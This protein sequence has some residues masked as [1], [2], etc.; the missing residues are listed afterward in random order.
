MSEEEEKP[1]RITVFPIPPVQG[2]HVQI[3]FDFD[4]VANLDACVLDVN[5]SPSAGSVSVQLTSDEPCV[6]LV[7]PDTAAGLE[8]VQPDGYSRDWLGTVTIP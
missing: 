4:D 2:M 1:Q 8:I 3:C 7:V 5:W 6:E